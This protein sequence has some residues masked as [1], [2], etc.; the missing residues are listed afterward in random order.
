MINM[1]LFPHLYSCCSLLVF[2]HIKCTK[3]VLKVVIELRH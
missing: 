1:Q 3:I 2:R